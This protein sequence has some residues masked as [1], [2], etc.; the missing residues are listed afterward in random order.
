MVITQ[1]RGKRKASGGRYKSWRKK[2]IHESGSLPAYT[3]LGE[4]VVKSR[5]TL[6]AGKKLFLL[7]AQTANVYDPK[8]K[9]YVQLKIE[10]IVENPANRHFV[11]RNIIT[12]GTIIKTEK[13]NARVTNRPGQ[14]GVINAVLV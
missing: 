14:E 13:G 12:K 7:S 8:E 2:R 11:R 1:H 4:K 10:T 6:A 3:K 5:R 9:K